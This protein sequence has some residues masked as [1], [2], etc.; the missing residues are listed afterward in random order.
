MATK[1]RKRRQSRREQ[2]KTDKNRVTM[3]DTTYSEPLREYT[4]FL[5]HLR[6]H[7]YARDEFTRIPLNLIDLAAAVVTSMITGR[8]LS[9]FGDKDIY[10]HYQDSQGYSAGSSYDEETDVYYFI[11]RILKRTQLSCTTLILALVYIDRFKARVAQ[12]LRRR[13]RLDQ[14]PDYD[15]M[16][17]TSIGNQRSCRSTD[18]L[19]D[20]SASVC[21]S[22][23]SSP[24]FLS[25][26]CSTTSSNTSSANSN[27]KPGQEPWSSI[28]LFLAAVICADKYLFDATYTNAEWADFTKGQYTTRMLNDLERRF[29]GHL[30]YR[31]YVSE[32]EF[33]GF[34]SYLEVILA[35]KQV[36]GRGLITF[37]YSDVR[38]LTQQLLPSYAG[39]LHFKA[40]Q[41]DMMS[42]I[43][44]VMAALTRVYLTVVGT[45]MFAAASYATVMELSAL[46]TVTAMDS[47]PHLYPHALSPIHPRASTCAFDSLLPV[48]ATDAM[49]VHP[50]SCAGIRSIV[51][52]YDRSLNKDDSRDEESSQPALDWIFSQSALPSEVSGALTTDDADDSKQQFDG[53]KNPSYLQL[54]SSAGGGSVAVVEFSSTC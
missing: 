29:L 4:T 41:G 10:A 47:I 23:A 50:I 39:R 44:Q 49:I 21:S 8:E 37:S 52:S 2:S 16:F 15:Q 11:Q 54:L 31:L 46:R 18:G 51:S 22:L 43:W 17:S 53:G 35:L 14:G 40:L 42:V 5:D 36:W 48:S 19:S 25:P 33:D 34:L 13:T 1:Q 12:T 30:Q 7:G 32:P 26:S 6:S 9:L 27:T 28:P 3:A 20:H 38:I 45:F 24:S